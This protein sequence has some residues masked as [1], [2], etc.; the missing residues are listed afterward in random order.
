VIQLHKGWS[1][2]WWSMVEGDLAQYNVLKGMEVMEFF[3]V[4]RVYQE[5]LK[6][7]IELA[8]KK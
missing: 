1:E 5:D 7:K 3:R 2:Q 4:M 6:R 8:K